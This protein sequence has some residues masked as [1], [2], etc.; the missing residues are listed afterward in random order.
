MGINAE[1]DKILY[2]TAQGILLVLIRGTGDVCR[3]G[4]LALLIPGS[5]SARVEEELFFKCSCS[6]KK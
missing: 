3:K 5:T 6:T 4:K 1:G 2:G